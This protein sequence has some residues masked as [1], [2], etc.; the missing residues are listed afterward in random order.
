[1]RS[2]Q[3]E[4]IWWCWNGLKSSSGF[5]SRVF[6]DVLFDCQSPVPSIIILRWLDLF[7]PNI[8]FEM[9]RSQIWTCIY[10][11]Y[12][13]YILYNH[14]MFIHVIFTTVPQGPLLSLRR[15]G[16]KNHWF[17]KLSIWMYLAHSGFVNPLVLIGVVGSC[18][19]I[20]KKQMVVR[21]LARKSCLRDFRVDSNVVFSQTWQSRPKRPFG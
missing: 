3:E 19:L 13:L 16:L 12:I 5:Q 8:I 1:M 9:L 21:C 10:I 7:R 17:G 2:V 15:R 6:F 11:I 14:G 4:R 18:S 20:L